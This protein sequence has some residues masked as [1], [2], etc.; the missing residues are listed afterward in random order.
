MKLAGP[1]TYPEQKNQGLLGAI[2]PIEANV[3]K[4][5]VNVE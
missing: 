1:I 4:R 3:Y 5:A 2:H